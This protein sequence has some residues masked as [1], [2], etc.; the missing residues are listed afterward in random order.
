MLSNTKHHIYELKYPKFQESIPKREKPTG[1]DYGSLTERQEKLRN[2]S[3]G[4]K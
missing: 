2:K 3:K 1:R 4:R